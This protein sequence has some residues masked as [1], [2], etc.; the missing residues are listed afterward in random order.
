MKKQGKSERK[1]ELLALEK[2]MWEQ[3]ESYMDDP[4]QLLEYLEFISRFP[5]YSVHN[6][7]LIASQRDGAVAVGSFGFYKA[8]GIKIKKG[9]RALKVLAPCHSTMFKRANG[10]WTSLKYATA[11]EKEAIANGEL[12]KVTWDYYRPVPVF[13]VTQTD[14][15]KEKYPE[16]FPNLH[17]DYATTAEFDA[18]GVYDGAM[19][20]LNKLGA[21]LTTADTASWDGGV[22]KGYY[23]PATKEI[24]LNPANT[25]TENSQVLLHELAH[26][27]LHS[28]EENAVQRELSLEHH[29]DLM[30]HEKELQ[31]EMTSYLI[32]QANGV[33]TT[34]QTT[35]Y[36]AHWTAKGQNI[37]RERL[38]V[39]FDEIVKVAE[40][41][42]GVIADHKRV[43][44][45]A[46]MA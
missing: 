43:M 14:L 26:A 33:D 17:V 38:A 46:V 36:I 4:A 3:V 18:Q 34:A 2:G 32:C 39:F 11:A 24:V 21:V 37:K 9:E 31:A 12:K 44:A 41:V 35:R 6:R 5:Q 19:A 8:Q 29:R 42:N 23:R 15:P 30:R 16:L 27:I 10:K 13:D 1:E 22:A 40:Y 28:A 20:I 45:P 25:A 7:M